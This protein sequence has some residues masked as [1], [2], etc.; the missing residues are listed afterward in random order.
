MLSSTSS[1]VQHGDSGL[2][3]FHSDL[4]QMTLHVVDHGVLPSPMVFFRTSSRRTSNN[5]LSIRCTRGTETDG[6]GAEIF[7]YTFKSFRS[8]PQ[9]L[10]DGIGPPDSE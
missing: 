2:T 10:T 1:Q 5:G 9:N 7:Y 8:R 3:V 4:D 6:C